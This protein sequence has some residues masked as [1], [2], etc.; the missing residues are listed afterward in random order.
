MPQPL[1]PWERPSTACTGGW[2]APGSVWAAGENLAPH[3]DS[4]PGPSRAKPVAILT[5]APQPTEQHRSNKYYNQ[6][7]CRVT[8]HDCGKAYIGHTGRRYKTM[9]AEHI[10]YKD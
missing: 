9:Y 8:C 4:N 10:A 1:Y 3:M 6:G 5:E 7:T 2:V